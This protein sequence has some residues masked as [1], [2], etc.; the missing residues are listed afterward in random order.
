MRMKRVRKMETNGN[1]AKSTEEIIKL[2]GQ[3]WD[4]EECYKYKYLSDFDFTLQKACDLAQKA[5]DTQGEDAWFSILTV[6]NEHSKSVLQKLKEECARDGL[7]NP[8]GQESE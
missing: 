7:K 1:E 4:Y 6:L 8:F 3:K 5:Y 2:Y